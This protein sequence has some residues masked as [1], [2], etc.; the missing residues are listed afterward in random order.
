LH[1]SYVPVI[2]AKKKKKYVFDL[3]FT[4]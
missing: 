3:A 2:N 4:C 1:S